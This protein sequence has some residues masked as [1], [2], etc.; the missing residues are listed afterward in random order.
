[1]NLHNRLGNVDDLA[2]L[3]ELSVDDRAQIRPR[4]SEP[5]MQFKAFDSRRRD[6]RNIVGLE[7]HRCPKA[8]GDFNNERRIRPVRRGGEHN[9]AAFTPPVRDRP[10][11]LRRLTQRTHECRLSTIERTAS[12]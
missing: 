1:M 11:L 3:G 9:M 2:R 4:R 7:I 8:F 6:P 5:G 12:A 10:D